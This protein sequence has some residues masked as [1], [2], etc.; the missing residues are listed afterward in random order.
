MQTNRK[1]GFTLVELMVVA[2]IVAILA[3]VAIPLMSGNKKRAVAT[4][5][6]AGC[7]TVRTAVRVYQAENGALPASGTAVTALPGITTNDLNGSYFSDGS[8]AYALAG[9]VYT[10]TATSDKGPAVGG[11]VILTVTNSTGASGW[12]GTLLQ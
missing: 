9:D 1:G 6:Q 7:S 4:E 12:G 10:I 2:I 8:Y 3:A 11:T 5:G